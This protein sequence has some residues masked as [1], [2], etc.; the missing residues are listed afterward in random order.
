MQESSYQYGE[1]GTPES[2]RQQQFS[3][4]PAS[5]MVYSV[6]SQLPQHSSFEQS[7]PA[8]QTRG[9]ANIEQL[10]SQLSIPQSQYYNT[11]DAPS[12]TPQSYAP[13]TPY[14]TQG[15]YR[16]TT[17]D[18]RPSTASEASPYQA[19]VAEYAQLAM[20][21]PSEQQQS[22]RGNDSQGQAGGGGASEEDF[23]QFQGALKDT[24]QQVLDG[25]LVMAGQRLLGLSEWLLNNAV[26][27]GTR[28]LQ[29]PP[30]TRQ[31]PKLPSY[32]ISETDL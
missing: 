16:S 29:V 31:L 25:Q 11:C 3:S 9:P 2:Q 7:L 19:E 12:I 13:T 32:S 5:N 23:A 21:N 26:D 22:S 14:Q 17:R 6:P 4:F 8:F 1:F 28:T 15:I 20:S 18:H 27:L 10:T 24:F 30:H